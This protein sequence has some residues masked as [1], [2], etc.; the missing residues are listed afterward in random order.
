M[1]DSY[2][3]GRGQDY[4]EGSRLVNSTGKRKTNLPLRK[5]KKKKMLE[6]RRRAEKTHWS[7]KKKDL[8]RSHQRRSRKRCDPTLAQ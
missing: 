4:L 5:K 3:V 2:Y 1:S 6:R 7:K 8:N